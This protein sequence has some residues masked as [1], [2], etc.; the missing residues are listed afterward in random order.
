MTEEE[1]LHINS[2]MGIALTPKPENDTR[3]LQTNIHHDTDI[4]IPINRY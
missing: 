3:K 4:K 1:T 2:S